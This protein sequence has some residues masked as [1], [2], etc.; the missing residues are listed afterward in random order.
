[1][2]KAK[3][4]LRAGLACRLYTTTPTVSTKAIC[5][6]INNRRFENGALLCK[7]LVVLLYTP[8][9]YETTEFFDLVQFD[10]YDIFFKYIIFVFFFRGIIIFR[11]L[12]IMTDNVSLYT[13]CIVITVLSLTFRKFLKLERMQWT[14]LC[15]S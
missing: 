12:M 9:L 2:A 4:P 10:P 1:M 15:T 3:T 14:P 11:P 5:E 7:C 13:T 8:N 6:A